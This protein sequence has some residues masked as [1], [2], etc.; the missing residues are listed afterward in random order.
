MGASCS[1]A[2]RRKCSTAPMRPSKNLS[3][4]NSRH[5]NPIDLMKDS[6]ET[7]LG[8]FFALAVVL[9]IVILE[10]LGGFGSFYHGRHFHALFKNVQDLKV[11][12]DVKM[13]GV[14]VGY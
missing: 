14:R 8:L 6:S 7:R 4:R 12:A 3:P 1:W 13:A 2:R 9:A 11:K 10:F 5:P